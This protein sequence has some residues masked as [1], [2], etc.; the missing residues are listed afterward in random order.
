MINDGDQM[1]NSTDPVL[2]AL[3]DVRILAGGLD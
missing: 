1:I 3:A 2:T